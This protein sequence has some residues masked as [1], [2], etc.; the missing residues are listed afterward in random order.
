MRMWQTIRISALHRHVH[1]HAYAALVLSGYYEEAGDSGRHLARAGD[2]VL[3]EALEAHRNRFPASEATVLNISL[4][5]QYAFQPGL[6]R[7]DDPDAVVRIAEKNE[8]EAAAVLLSLAETQEPECH[9]WP[10]EL[11]A[12]LLQDPSLNL[13]TWSEAN[14]ITPWTLSRG[15][16]QVFDIAPSA[17]RARTRAR[18]AWK[19][20]QTTDAALAAIAAQLGFADQS[21]MT[22]SVKS[23]TGKG[24]QAWRSAA[25]RFKTQ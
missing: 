11:A 12:A 4:P 2:V 3:H 8:A 24:P 17:F 13:T 6:G 21:H 18:Q 10:E 5:D 22:R 16:A 25:N 9:D 15:F 14:G 1:K 19:A 7:V 20:I 23:M